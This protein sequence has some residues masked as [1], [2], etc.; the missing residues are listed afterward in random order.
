M[1]RR[2]AE[3]AEYLAAAR[4]EGKPWG[5][6]R[7]REETDT[8]LPECRLPRQVAQRNHPS[9]T[10]TRQVRARRGSRGPVRVVTARP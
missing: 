5:G 2:R 4:S 7:H 1:P 10:R 3:P 6:R 9:A 8:N